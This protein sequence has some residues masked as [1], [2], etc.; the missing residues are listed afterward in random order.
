M[1]WR[2]KNEE[3]EVKVEGIMLGHYRNC[4]LHQDTNRGESKFYAYNKSFF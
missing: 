2:E 4:E 1:R 3:V